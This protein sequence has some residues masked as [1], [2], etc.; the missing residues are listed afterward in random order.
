MTELVFAV[1]IFHRVGL[2]DDVDQVTGFGDS[3]EDLA[4][5][6]QQ[7]PALGLVRPVELPNVRV[8]AVIVVSVPADEGD[9]GQP[10]EA[11]VPL[12]EKLEFDIERG[13]SGGVV[14]FLVER[15]SRKGAHF[16]TEF[17][18]DAPVAREVTGPGHSSD[19]YEQEPGGPEADRLQRHRRALRN[20]WIA[21]ENQR[22][23]FSRAGV[24]LASCCPV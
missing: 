1:D 13:R 9:E 18:G 2:I 20:P 5:A 15:F 16:G 3:P 22:A 24:N 23:R 4:H 12:R 7:R 8:G 21:A 10:V 6:H 17:P 14:L 11:L 19:L